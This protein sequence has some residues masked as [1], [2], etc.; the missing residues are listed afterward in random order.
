M[1]ANLKDAIFMCDSAVERTKITRGRANETLRFKLPVSS[2]KMTL[3]HLFSQT[4]ESVTI[5]T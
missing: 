2:T 1:D 5:L 3:R 4:K